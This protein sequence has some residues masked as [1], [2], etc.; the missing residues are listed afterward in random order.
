VLIVGWVSQG[1]VLVLFILSSLSHNHFVVISLCRFDES[2]GKPQETVM[3][4]FL[5]FVNH[6]CNGTANLGER[7]G[8]PSM[9]TEWNVDIAAGIPE[10]LE[11]KLNLAYNP[12]SDRDL[13]RYA[14]NCVVAID[15][16]KGE[17]LY[18]N[19]MNFGGDEFFVE[20]VLS[21]R[22]QCSGGLGL[23]EMYQRQQKSRDGAKARKEY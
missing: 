9:F 3:S 2:F 18:D 1:D 22:E 19:Y 17:E 15:V 7:G 12:V 23:V 21:L 10:D 5:T 13:V 20:M 4:H 6:G 8:D 11:T 16:P 14:T